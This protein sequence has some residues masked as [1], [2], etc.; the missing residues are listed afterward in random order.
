VS[1]VK[2]E[3]LRTGADPKLMV[4]ELAATALRRSE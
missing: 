1:A 4:F 3:L 2:R